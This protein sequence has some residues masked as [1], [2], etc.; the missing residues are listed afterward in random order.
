MANRQPNLTDATYSISQS[1]GK[2]ESWSHTDPMKKIDHL[3]RS[4]GEKH[5][6]NIPAPIY[7]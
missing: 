4:F 2:L 7:D 6:T 3:G 5:W 1:V